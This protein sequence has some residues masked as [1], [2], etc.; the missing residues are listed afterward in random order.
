MRERA[1]MDPLTGLANRS[2][3]MR[4]GGHLVAG[5]RSR[6]DRIMVTML[7]L[8]GFKGINDEHGHDAGDRVLI[9][10]AMALRSAI[11]EGDVVARLGGDE[12]VTVQVLRR[13]ADAV[14]V[15][16]RVR[17]DVERDLQTRVAVAA[18]VGVTMGVAE[19]L[20]GETDLKA[21][22]TRAD[23]AL[24]HGKQRAK[25]HVYDGNSCPTEHVS[26]SD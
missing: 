19:A 12:F 15:A 26:P 17:S 6:G 2:E 16:E 23:T 21:L 1:T 4:R 5:A 10:V 11:R 24:I 8:D 3:L 9:G 14:T 25:G 7:D 13:R 18:S 20:D 22:V